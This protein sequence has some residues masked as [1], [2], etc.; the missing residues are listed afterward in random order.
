M[1]YTEHILIRLSSSK[2]ISHGVERV[3]ERRGKCRKTQR[4]WRLFGAK[5]YLRRAFLS[6]IY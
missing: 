2:F 6:C 4:T 5:R 1:L 3:D